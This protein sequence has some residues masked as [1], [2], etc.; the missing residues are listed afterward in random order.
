[1]KV[2]AIIQARTGSSRLPGKVLLPLSGRPMLGRVVERTRQAK[3]IDEV[4]V[5][6]TDQPADTEIADL[7]RAEDWPVFAGSEH[8]VLD[9][10]YKAASEHRAELVVRITSD[11]PMIDADVIDAVVQKYMDYPAADYV[12]CIL[13]PRTYPRGLDVEAFPFEVLARTW[14]EAKRAPCREHVTRYIHRQPHRFTLRGVFSPTDY[15]NLRWTVD[16][17][18]DFDLAQKIYAYFGHDQFGWRDILSAYADH[19][20][21]LTVNA[22][23]VQKAA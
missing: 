22:H 5:A 6:T 15:S 16:T 18:E 7:C 8:D 9:R 13:P 14:R 17:E 10:Y 1:M 12:S 2:V 21:W 3:T 20:E 23:I 19:P 4:V 11:C